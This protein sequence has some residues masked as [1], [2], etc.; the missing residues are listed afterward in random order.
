MPN[1]K[2][3]FLV[4]GERARLFPVLSDSSKEGR[5]TSIFLA[6]LANVDEFADTLLSSVGRKIGKLSQVRTY[7]EV[8]FAKESDDMR[9]RPDGLIEVKTG[10]AKW[11]ALVEAKIG[12]AELSSEQIE[13]YLKIAKANG[14]DAVITIS[15]QFASTPSHHPVELRGRTK[16]AAGLYHW[17]WM[18]ILTEADL[19]LTNNGVSDVDQRVILNELRRFL[20]HDSTGVKG[21]ERMPRAWPDLVR[22][23]TTGQQIGPRS[24]ELHDVIDAWHQEV[25]DLGLIL[26]RQLGVGVSARLSRD[27]AQNPD[28]RVKRDIDE[29][30]KDQCLR[31]TLSI[32]EAAANLDVTV[33]VRAKSMS[34]GMKLAAPADKKGASARISW[35]LRQIKTS[36]P[37]NIHIRVH[38]P[39]R[40]FNQYELEAL[41]QDVDQAAKAYLDSVPSYLEVVLNRDTGSRFS[42]LKGFI[43]DIEALVPDFYKI[44]GGDLRAWNPPAPQLRDDRLVSDDVSTE[45]IAEDAEEA[46]GQIS[47]ENYWKTKG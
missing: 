26:S 30:V 46:V 12:N 29:F 8:C 37:R 33:D 32:P 45:A 11:N 6:C 23:L 15:N 2:P 22:S 31:T 41:R 18:H 39:H 7:T 3:L 38:W 35:L 19:L 34:A 16:H 20:S 13:S 9:G 17:S 24:T 36:D 14:I 25:R 21:F 44:V 28:K 47:G 40:G 42:Q 1:E 4:Q 5:A 10:S 43:E 27:L